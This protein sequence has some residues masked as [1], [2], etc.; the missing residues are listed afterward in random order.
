MRS[1][2][3]KILSLAVLAAFLAAPLVAL[4]AQQAPAGK[5]DPDKVNLNTAPLDEL[6]KLPRIGPK[7]AQRIIDF[8][9]QNVPF[10]RVEDL[11][12]VNGVGEK[13]FSQLRNLVAV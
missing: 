11:L 4:E 5:P 8:R 1:M 13:L 2:S 12:K 7:V 6:Q 9:K 3:S 10:K